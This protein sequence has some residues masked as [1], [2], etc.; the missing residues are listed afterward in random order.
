MD[1]IADMLTII[2]NGYRASKAEVT[3][4]YSKLKEKLAEKLVTLGYLQSVAKDKLDEKQILRIN[5]RYEKG[6]PEIEGIKRISKPGLRVYKGSD[7]LPYVYGGLGVAIVSTNK[8]LLS[9]K[10][11]RRNKVGGEVLCEVW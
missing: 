2:R 6:K 11:A 10:E 5:L 1:S 7:K 4:P 8:G 3:T 9:D